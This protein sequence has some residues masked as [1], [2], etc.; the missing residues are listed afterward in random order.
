MC[1]LMMW[2]FARQESKWGCQAVLLKGVNLPLGNAGI[3][4]LS[5]T[6][7]GKTSAVCNGKYMP[8]YRMLVPDA[9]I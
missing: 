4:D 1:L 5:V 7:S 8:V 9:P 6:N 2:D 3:G